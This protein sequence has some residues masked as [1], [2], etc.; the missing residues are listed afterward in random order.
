MPFDNQDLLG[1]VVLLVHGLA[2]LAHC[3]GVTG[4]GGNKLLTEG[5]VLSLLLT[6][7]L[8]LGAVGAGH[9]HELLS[10]FHEGLHLREDADEFGGEGGIGGLH[11]GVI[12][13]VVDLIICVSF[14][15][16]VFNL[17]YV[18]LRHLVQKG[19]LIMDP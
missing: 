18:C 7:D 12:L 5:G 15:V 3:G 11:W 9:L 10:A 13:E 6:R 1:G 19:E 4:F 17:N 8:V 14:S 16:G 2:E